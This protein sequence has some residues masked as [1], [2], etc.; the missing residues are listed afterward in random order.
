VQLVLPVPVQLV[1][2]VP[3]PLVTA[4]ASEPAHH[5]VLRLRD[6]DFVRRGGCSW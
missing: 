5:H 1:L 4:T 3:V 2:P 6:H